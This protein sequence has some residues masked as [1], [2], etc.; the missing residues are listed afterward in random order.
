MFVTHNEGIGFPHLGPGNFNPGG[1]AHFYSDGKCRNPYYPQRDT[2]FSHYITFYKIVG[3]GTSVPEGA[4]LPDT[5]TNL[6]L[7]DAGQYP[8]Y[9]AESF[10][11]SVRSTQ[12]IQDADAEQ[13]AAMVPDGTDWW[14]SPQS[15]SS[16]VRAVLRGQ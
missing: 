9:V 3:H 13:I 4:Y 12:G 14:Q 8:F 2:A 16:P 7:S 5:I 11:K 15:S 6:P 10:R 1:K